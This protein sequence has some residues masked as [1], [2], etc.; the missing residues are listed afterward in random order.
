MKLLFKLLITL[1]ICLFLFLILDTSRL[2]TYFYI[3]LIASV[4]SSLVYY[5]IKERHNKF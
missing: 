2:R 4:G 3:G 1:E 5:W